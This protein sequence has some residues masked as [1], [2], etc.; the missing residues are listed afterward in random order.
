[1]RNENRRLII[2]NT[3]AVRPSAIKPNSK[4]KFF[5]KT[6]LVKTE[7]YTCVLHADFLLKK[8]QV[9]QSSRRFKI[10]KVCDFFRGTNLLLM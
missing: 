8:H 10:T 2:G 7:I 6:N 1:M 5:I 9:S 3:D 4:V